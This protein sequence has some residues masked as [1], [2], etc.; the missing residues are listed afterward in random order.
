MSNAETCSAIIR[1]LATPCGLVEL[2]RRAGRSKRTTV[3]ALAV[4]VAEGTVHAAGKPSTHQRR[5][6]LTQAEAEASSAAACEAFRATRSAAERARVNAAR[7][8]RPDRAA[9][10]RE[11]LS[12]GPKTAAEIAS[13]MGLSLKATRGLLERTKLPGFGGRMNRPRYF[14]AT[15]DEARAAYEAAPVRATTSDAPPSSG[16]RTVL[17]AAPPEIEVRPPA[18]EP[19]RLRVV[20]ADE[21]SS[22]ADM[23]ACTPFGARMS[24]ASCV[25]RQQIG[26]KTY[27]QLAAIEK[28]S[29]ARAVSLVCRACDVGQVVGA[30]LDA[31][32]L[33]V[34]RAS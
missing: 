6:A 3:E 19:Y 30:R 32:R 18:G 20:R 21:V 12:S 33:A 9:Q 23:F 22:P 14:A 8:R 10:V 13:A 26:R 1:A 4:L 27:A 16:V 31:A 34:R 15:V 25:K 28:V 11:V 7:S 2:A 17:A 29:G 5:Y 24:A